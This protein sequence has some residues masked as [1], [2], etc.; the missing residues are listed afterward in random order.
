MQERVIDRVSPALSLSS[1]KP[2][3]RNSLS[4]KAKWAV[5]SF[6]FLLF[7]Y[8]FIYLFIN[9][10]RRRVCFSTVALWSFSA[11][12]GPMTEISVW[13]VLSCTGLVSLAVNLFMWIFFLFQFI[14]RRSCYLHGRVGLSLWWF[15][16]F[17]LFN[18]LVTEL[19]NVTIVTQVG[20]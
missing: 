4:L 16:T 2:K 20:S 6:I 3:N 10:F 18:L 8:L 9:F 13:N 14:D 5:F 19:L 12:P 11:A 17:L 15:F 7:I 1:F